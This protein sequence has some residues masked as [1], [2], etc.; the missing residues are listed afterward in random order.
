[1]GEDVI[2]FHL[3]KGGCMVKWPR[4]IT[5]VR[6]AESAYNVLAAKK[7]KDEEYQRFRALYEQELRER[8]GNPPRSRFSK[9]LQKKAED[10]AKKFALGV[11]DEN[12]LITAKGKDQARITGMEIGALIPKPEVIICSPYLR[13]RE[14]LRYMS[15]QWPY[16]STQM[17][18]TLYDI[19]VRE[20]E[21]GKALLYN[22]KRVFNIL[23]PD[24]F[25]LREQEG[26]YYTRW[27]NGESVCDVQDRLRFLVEML[28]REYSGK[29]VLIV[30]HHMTILAI[31]ANLHGWSPE[32][33]MQIDKKARPENCG[34]TMYRG[35]PG[36][37][38]GR[39]KLELV[40]YNNVL[41]NRS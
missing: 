35:V 39:G 1:M 5:L 14:T 41:W 25:I 26:G 15:T 19:R 20:Q 18:N 29:D 28:I 33:F 10:I 6:H 7:E 32:M 34:V 9:A 22:D 4:S 36:G 24:E 31:R 8:K 27:P 40:T 23:H 16:L 30:T 38:A 37:R 12:T 13:T 2:S 11:S 21:H 17:E 3:K